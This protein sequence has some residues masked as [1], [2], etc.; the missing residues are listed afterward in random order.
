M[1][2]RLI[3]IL[4]IISLCTFYVNADNVID[5]L[6]SARTNIRQ[7]TTKS[8]IAWGTPLSNGPIKTLILGSRRGIHE[9]F[10]FEKACDLTPTGLTISDRIKKSS[11]SQS[12]FGYDATQKLIAEKLKQ[13]WNL[14]ILGK[15]PWTNISP[16]NRLIILQKVHKGMGL[17]YISP[18]Y[19][20]KYLRRILKEKMITPPESIIKHLKTNSTL[21]NSK[22]HIIKYAKLGN[23][24]I[25][26]VYYPKCEETKSRILTPEIYEY[27]NPLEYQLYMEEVS[28]L[29][30]WTAKRYS[31]IEISLSRRADAIICKLKQQ[32]KKLTGYLTLKIW[33]SQGKIRYTKKTII[34]ATKN[35]SIN[36]FHLPQLPNGYFLAQ[37][38]M[39]KDEKVVN[40]G[41]LR[42]SI[43]NN[44]QIKKFTLGKYS[45]ETNEPITGE[46]SITGE[47]KGKMIQLTVRDNLGRTIAMNKLP[48]TEKVDFKIKLKKPLVALHFIHAK[49]MNGSTVLA[50]ARNEFVF[51]TPFNYKT[52]HLMSWVKSPS[53]FA[54]GLK[55]LRKYGVDTIYS[56]YLPNKANKRIVA[57]IRNTTKA[58]QWYIPMMWRT[59]SHN[60]GVRKPCLTNTK[61]TGVFTNKM[62]R[63]TK[64][65]APY[66][67][68]AY[69]LGGEN[70]LSNNEVCA[71]PSCATHFQTYLKKKYQTI[72]NLNATWKTRHTSFKNIPPIFKKS[73][74]K[75]KNVLPWYDFRHNMD[76]VY[77]EFQNKGKA[78]IRTVAPKGVIGEESIGST[79]TLGGLSFNN[80]YDNYKFAIYYINYMDGELNRALKKTGTISGFYCGSYP[81]DF[82]NKKYKYKWHIWNTLFYNMNAVVWWIGD[83][84]TFEGTTLYPPAL[85]PDL[86]P[87]SWFAQM[88]DDFM[89][90]KKSGIAELLLDCHQK[91]SNIAIYYSRNSQFA[92][93]LRGDRYALSAFIQLIKD[94]GMQGDIVTDKDLLSENFST[95]NRIILILPDCEVLH[96][97]IY[98]KIFTYM[99]NGGIVIGN[100]VPQ[101][102]TNGEKIAFSHKNF[103]L[104]NPKSLTEYHKNSGMGPVKTFTFSDDGNL[105]RNS[106]K[107]NLPMKKLKGIATL[108]TTGGKDVS[109]CEVRL[110]KNGDETYLGIIRSPKH[111]L[112]ALHVNVILNKK[113]YVK[114]IINPSNNPP[115]LMKNISITMTKGDVKLFA[116]TQKQHYN[117]YTV[118][119]NQNKKSVTLDFATNSTKT[120]RIICVSVIAPT[121]RIN[122]YYSSNVVLT[123]GKASYNI[124]FALNDNGEWNVTTKDAV[125]AE[126]KTL[127]ITL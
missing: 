43:K 42:L 112:K 41:I 121:G 104:F 51:R 50:E 89:S 2:K 13:N 20:D 117:S 40:W 76:N 66:F 107:Q 48:A 64:L 57:E 18:T 102:D 15:V 4:G 99:N 79:S 62:T 68:L 87:Y 101:I 56:Y 24:N 55:Q 81:A 113:Y 19:S 12:P 52:M 37:L 26:C 17:L 14:L 86:T 31:K 95:S 108:Q 22:D 53:T 92:A 5:E 38:T 67:P 30:L 78:A 74:A 83:S 47:T 54:Q 45:Y 85:R 118:A 75:C 94:L 105:I 96:P 7:S 91:K 16:K 71:S 90:M 25:C 77:I 97:S 111:D 21:L 82:N 65:I 127:K 109:D 34:S 88:S 10:N 63:L 122:K 9:V 49:V 124:P 33:D 106:F 123:N 6:S 116:L 11:N 59:A 98:A 46:I 120:T 119:M 84:L 110:W 80:L 69:S 93:T 103:H 114:S 44:T 28:T 58:N 70:D 29:A 100:V 23:G 61:F 32:K 115:L 39:T 3:C 35:K 8:I 125:S 1:N 126:T 72:E 60:K 27:D 36:E 73:M